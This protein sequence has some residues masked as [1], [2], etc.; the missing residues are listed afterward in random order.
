MTRLSDRIKATRL[1]KGMSQAELA[2][3]AQVSQPT[4]ANWESGSHVPRSTVLDR[5]SDALDVETDW[6]LTGESSF[7]LQISTNY[8]SQPTQHIPI[9]S[10]YDMVRNPI[11]YMPFSSQL[12]DLMAIAFDTDQ[13]QPTHILI[14]THADV[15]GD[16]VFY[17]ENSVVQRQS[18]LPEKPNRIIGQV[19]AE[20]KI[21]P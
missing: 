15:S 10:A 6:L 20:I 21:T 17:D 5:I 8:L 16:Y 19:F 1:N 11:G 9:Y 2:T 18:D 14:C 4:V 12:T 3:A 7:D 13:T